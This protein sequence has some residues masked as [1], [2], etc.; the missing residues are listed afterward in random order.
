M[1]T[2]S[3]PETHSY[4]A[5]SP[6]LIKDALTTLQKPSNAVESLQTQSFFTETKVESNE[7]SAA[8]QVLAVSGRNL[9]KS[10]S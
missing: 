1:F 4:R 9:K 10:R 8:R 5:K 2:K 6:R 3:Q 7:K